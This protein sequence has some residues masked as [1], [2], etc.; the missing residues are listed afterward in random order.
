MKELKGQEII[1]ECTTLVPGIFRCEAISDEE[2]VK[3]L[4]MVP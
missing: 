2:Q 4:I 1:V 3:R